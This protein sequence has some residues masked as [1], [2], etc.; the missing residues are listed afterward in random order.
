MKFSKVFADEAKEYVESG[1]QIS[2]ATEKD[3]TNLA[4]EVRNAI[5]SGDIQNW[6]Q[7]KIID[8]YMQLAGPT[9]TEKKARSI[10]VKLIKTPKKIVIGMLDTALKMTFKM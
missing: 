3:L 10:R 4:L 1:R 5:N 7:K 2:D 6:E 8:T 9:L